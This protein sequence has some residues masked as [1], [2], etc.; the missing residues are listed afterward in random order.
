MDATTTG[1]KLPY[2]IMVNIMF[3][4]GHC[5][6]QNRPVP[7]GRIGTDRALQLWAMPLRFEV[8]NVPEAL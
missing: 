1:H 2:V 5:E 8:R 3:K 7:P 6:N 4:L